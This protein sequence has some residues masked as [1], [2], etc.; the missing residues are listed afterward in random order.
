MVSAVGQQSVI[1][2]GLELGADSYIVKPF[3]SEQFAKIVEEVMA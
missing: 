1:D 2:T 3:T